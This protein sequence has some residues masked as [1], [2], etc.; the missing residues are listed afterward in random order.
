MVIPVII[1]KLAESAVGATVEH[2]GGRFLI[3]NYSQ[4]APILSLK[5]LD[6]VLTSFLVVGGFRD[7]WWVA[8]LSTETND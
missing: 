6:F 3:G 5:N 4:L 1:H 8:T 2:S 7:I